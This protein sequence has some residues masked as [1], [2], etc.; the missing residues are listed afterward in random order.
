VRRVQERHHTG[1]RRRTW[2][3]RLAIAAGCLSTL[4]LVASA[5]GLT[6][7]FRKY[8]RLPRVELSGVLDQSV[9]S[10]EPENYLIVG[11]DNAD[12]LPGDDTVR[13][14][15][16]PT[17][18]S[19]TIM[20][21]RTDPATSRAALLSLPRDLYVTL[22]DGR[23]PARINL[24]IER[25]GA[26]L[27][28]RT[29]ADNFAIPIHHYV[30]VDFAAFRGLVDA[31]DGVPVPIPHPARDT[32]SGLDIP[33]AGCHTLDPTEALSYV[34]S[35][36]YEERIDGRWVMDPRSDIGRIERQ[37]DFIRRA[38]SRAIDRGARNPGTLDQLID[39]G[40]QGITVDGDLTA[41]DIF[42]LGTR[43]RSFDPDD[44]ATYSVEGTPDTVGEA[45]ILRLVEG[46]ETE[47]TLSIFRGGTAEQLEP[48]GVR[49]IVRNG[50]GVTRQGAEATEALRSVGFIANVSGDEPGGGAEGTVV[51]H[52]PGQEAA[53]DLV[54]RWLEGG[55]RLEEVDDGEGIELV[56]GVD[57]QGTRTDAA[58][59]TSTTTQTTL[60]EPTTTTTT[61]ERE[62]S[63]ERTTTSIDLAQLDC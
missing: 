8:E 39:V 35:R 61:S 47:A 53:A 55:A 29:I 45:Q 60:P 20:I 62:G 58:P 5:A 56:T 46:P 14:G 36:Y 1:R 11:I 27:L 34:R 31:V 49:L 57:W 54:A 41:D 44:L 6:Y 3:Q 42:D 12:N 22:A 13:I 19:D 51:R 2:G 4:G 48:E 16:D 37:Q 21:L 9:D 23:G 63:G 18:R 40:L 30:Q 15:R 32:E 50:T 33:E 24:A 38:L 52:P 59:S 26:P 17:L 10:G 25:G 7:V 43:F 28:I